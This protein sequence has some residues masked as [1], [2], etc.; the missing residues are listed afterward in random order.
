MPDPFASLSCFNKTNNNAIPIG[1]MTTKP[2]SSSN[3]NSGAN[4]SGQ[5]LLTQHVMVPSPSFDSGGMDFLAS[6]SSGSVQASSQTIRNQNIQTNNSFQAGVKQPPASKPPSNI[7]YNPALFDV[8]PIANQF[9]SFAPASQDDR[10]GL[11]P[12]STYTPTTRSSGDLLIFLGS[13]APIG[14]ENNPLGL[15]GLSIDELKKRRVPSS[16][17]PEDTVFDES[18]FKELSPE[19]TQIMEMGF[20]RGS[21][22]E[23]LENCNYSLETAVAMLISG[24]GEGSEHSSLSRYGYFSDLL[25]L[26]LNLRLNLEIRCSRQSECAVCHLILMTYLCKVEEIQILERQRS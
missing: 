8:K 6:A 9:D 25:G 24:S 12:S 3:S 15:L 10:L 17:I 7:M 1:K 14:E 22:M 5:Q 11:G 21:A 4:L 19:V 23:A 20:S 16:S 2:L 18:S 13:P 26:E